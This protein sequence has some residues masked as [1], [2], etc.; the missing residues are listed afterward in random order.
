MEGLKMT[1]GIFVFILCIIL[2]EGSGI[3]LQAYRC[4]LL[5]KKRPPLGTYS[6]TMPGVL[7]RSQGVGDKP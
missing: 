1:T 5:I 6:T 7:C 2:L 4:T 3:G